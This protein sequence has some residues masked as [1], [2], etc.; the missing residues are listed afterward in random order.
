MSRRLTQVRSGIA[1]IEALIALAVMAFGMLAIVGMQGTL[2]QNS[3]LSRQRAEAVRIAQQQIERARAYAVLVD[4][5]N[6]ATNTFSSLASLGAREVAGVAG[7]STTF[8]LATQVPEGAGL[9][10]LANNLPS[11][12]GLN[13]TVTWRD[14]TD[15]EQ[16]VSLSTAIHGV[17][18]ELAGTLSIP[19]NGT[20]TSSA[21]GRNRAIPWNTTPLSGGR[22]GFVPPQPADGTVVWVFDNVT[23]ILRVCTIVNLGVNLAAAGNISGCDGVEFEKYELLTGDVNFANNAALQATADDALRPKGTAFQVAVQFNQ[24]APSGLAISPSCFTELPVLGRSTVAYFCAVPIGAERARLP[25]S[26]YSVVTSSLLP[27]EPVVGGFSTCRYTSI[28]ADS[29]AP[30]NN[31]HPRSYS[32]VKGPLAGQNFLVVRV[33]SNNADDCPDGLPLPSGTTTFPQP[34]S[35]PAP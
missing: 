30:A 24:T 5:A 32:D 17:A 16:A 4:P 8:T 6:P 14:R 34:Q 1:L 27:T 20:P 23:G 11:L 9:P 25:W 35:A 26:G 29:P 28:R 22:S 13:V 12:K 3:D 10:L 31:R 2:R 7:R 18:P 21:G 15:I 19:P 33:V